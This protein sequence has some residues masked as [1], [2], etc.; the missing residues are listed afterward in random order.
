MGSDC[1]YVSQSEKH[2]IN[3]D[4]VSDIILDPQKSVKINISLFN[5]KAIFIQ[6]M[7]LPISLA[8]GQKK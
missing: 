4:L 6:P 8:F 2:T 1:S 5:F 3:N 7:V